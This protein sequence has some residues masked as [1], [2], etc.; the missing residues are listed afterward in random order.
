MYVTAEKLSKKVGNPGSRKMVLTSAV[1][2][3]PLGFNKNKLI[4]GKGPR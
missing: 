3:W 2:L 1:N 4:T